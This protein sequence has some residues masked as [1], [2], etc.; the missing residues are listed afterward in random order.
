MNK[1]GKAFDLVLWD[2]D[3]CL[4]DSEMLACAVSAG[5]FTQAGYPITTEQFV[6]RFAGRVWRENAAEIERERGA[7]FVASLPR[8]EA[9]KRTLERFEKELKPISGVAEAMRSMACAS[10]VASGSRTN[11][12]V[13]ALD[14]TGLR[15]FFS[16]DRIFSS[17]QVERGKPAPDL[18][19]FAAEKMGVLP[20]RCLV[21]EDSPHGVRAAKAAGMAVFAFMGG[22]HV[23]PV[24]RERV[25]ALAPDRMFDKMAE[26]PALTREL[27][28]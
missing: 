7:A 1:D 26:L 12:I 16:D 6:E 8:E 28:A 9:H 23:T 4:I 19:L 15:D 25:A 20:E 22:S 3:G 13:L 18:F 21:I 27:R 14:L 24:W 17:E 2:L 11:H 5:L 10:C